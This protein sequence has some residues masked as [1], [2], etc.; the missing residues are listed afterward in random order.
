MGEAAM[1]PLDIFE[2]ALDRS[3][4]DAEVQPFRVY[5]VLIEG[6]DDPSA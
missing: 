6:E 2:L 4:P 1:I 3:S 5:D